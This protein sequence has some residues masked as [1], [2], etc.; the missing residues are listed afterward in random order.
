MGGGDL[1]LKKQWHP[2]T[3]KNQEMVWKREQQVLAEQ[4]K[5]E[6]L[7][8]ELQAERSMQELN[9]LSAAHGKFEPKAE[10]IDWMYQMGA[11]DNSITTVDK[12][13]YLLG[14]KPLDSLLRQEE[15]GEVEISVGERTSTAY[16][17]FQ[18]NST[19]DMQSKIRDD[20]LLAIK[21]K[22]QQMVNTVLSNPYALKQLQKADKKR[23]KELKRAAK[24]AGPVSRNPDAPLAG[25]VIVKRSKSPSPEAGFAYFSKKKKRRSLSPA[26][27]RGGG[28]DSCRRDSRRD[29]RRGDESKRHDDPHGRRNDDRRSS[30]R[31]DDRNTSSRNDS[32]HTSRR[33]DDDRHTAKAY[34]DRNTSRRDDNNRHSSRRDDDDRHSSRRDD[35]DR[36]TTKRGED[37]HTNFHESTSLASERARKI[38]KMQAN[39][40]ELS[41]SRDQMLANLDSALAEEQKEAGAASMDGFY[42]E[43]QR[44][45]MG[46]ETLGDRLGRSRAYLKKE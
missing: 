43:V 8:K 5:S 15:K 23:A 35:D 44:G 24:I 3:F 20:P 21:K 30:R 11:Q 37:K 39:A 17:G 10:R 46:N 12:E 41:E 38:A 22:E 16:Y 13:A 2:L 29:E 7:K 4:H 27:G 32:R 31:G 33:D 1:N 42:K 40:T 28:G 36:H 45:V 6:Q 34:N 18:A 14:K 25:A 26:E 19:R 9:A